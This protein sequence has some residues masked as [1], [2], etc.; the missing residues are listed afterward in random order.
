[1]LG[2]KE[3]LK[4]SFYFFLFI[5]VN[6]VISSFNFC[7]AEIKKL[8]DVVF[9][10]KNS[11]QFQVKNARVQNALSYIS[12]KNNQDSI[13]FYL[14]FSNLSSDG[15][16]KNNK[17][18]YDINCKS[19]LYTIGLDIITYKL[20]SGISLSAESYYFSRDK[21]MQSEAVTEEEKKILAK[22][23]FLY[24]DQHRLLNIYGMY[25]ID[26]AY[27][28]GG[29]DILLLKDKKTMSSVGGRLGYMVNH[30][31]GVNFASLLGVDYCIINDNLPVNKKVE[32]MPEFQRLDNK[33]SLESLESLEELK[34]TNSKGLK[35]IVELRFWTNRESFNFFINGNI[36]Y[37]YH[38][39]RK[40]TRDKNLCYGI[41]GGLEYKG[42][43]LSFYIEANRKGISN[44][45]SNVINMQMS[46]FI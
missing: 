45:E 4:L 8:Q 40:D 21:I 16:L 32:N 14:Y 13:S 35:P 7:I 37:I 26:K 2:I 43:L 27:I 17:H 41:G 28:Q 15:I 42:K 24:I 20:M 46:L 3:Y 1:M 5:F 10:E 44:Y 33:E 22:N 23:S 12:K 38:I 19:K 34:F 11:N 36:G 31:A 39:N 25:L 6:I 9:F 30:I 18:N 29:L